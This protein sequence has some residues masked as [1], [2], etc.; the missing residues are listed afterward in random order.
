MFLN[1][2]NIFSFI[3]SINQP[4]PS[5]S[6]FLAMHPIPHFDLSSFYSISLLFGFRISF[7]PTTFLSTQST[8]SCSLSR[9]FLI[10]ILH[11]TTPVYYSLLNF[12]MN[13]QLLPDISFYGSFQR[14][15]QLVLSNSMN[16]HSCLMKSSHWL[17]FL[18]F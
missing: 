3:R 17:Y 13:F 2:P 12:Q 8:H 10:F 1:I 15:D 7:N 16:L 5:Y 6:I 18:T 14:L 9:L 11:L 4:F